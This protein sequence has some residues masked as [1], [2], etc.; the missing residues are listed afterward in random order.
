MFSSYS[1]LQQQNSQV[2]G[3]AINASY[4]AICRASVSITTLLN[5][6]AT[7]L[8]AAPTPSEYRALV[9]KSYAARVIDS[10]IA[11]ELNN[12]SNFV[13]SAKF[14]SPGIGRRQKSS[15]SDIDAAAP[16]VGLTLNARINITEYRDD[17]I[18]D[19]ATIKMKASFKCRSV[20]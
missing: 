9:T 14:L 2:A 5:L 17:A 10:I 7:Y 15:S 11:H 20:S 4:R 8:S 16:G 18:D 13:D 6:S 1:K 12:T 19:Y 3:G